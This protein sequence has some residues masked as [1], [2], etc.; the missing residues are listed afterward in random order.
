MSTTIRITSRFE[1]M[2]KVLV[3]IFLLSLFTN[4]YSQRLSGVWISNDNLIHKSSN[5]PISENGVS[6]INFD[7][8]QLTSLNT[9][10][11][12]AIQRNKKETAVKFKGG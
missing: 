11:S 3:P 7:K 1:L 4:L 6:I 2:K 8:N 5:S 12:K 9:S 10:D